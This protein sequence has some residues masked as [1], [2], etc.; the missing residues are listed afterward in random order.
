MNGSVVEILALGLDHVHVAHQQDRLGPRLA[1]RAPADDQRR[2]IVLAGGRASGVIGHDVDVSAGK[3]AALNWSATYCAIAGTLWRPITVGVLITCSNIAWVGVVLRL[4]QLAARPRARRE[5]KQRERRTVRR[6]DGA[7]RFLSPEI[8]LRHATFRAQRVKLRR[9]GPSARYSA[10]CISSRRLTVRWNSKVP[11]PGGIE[12]CG[13][14][15]GGGEQLHL[16][17]VQRVDQ[18][19]EA[20]RLVA[21]LA[22]P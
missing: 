16:M 14:G 17:L 2:G 6:A 5:R 9:R 21:H 4:R 19:D 15:V 10:L 20:R 7:L 22:G 12:S 1:G 8:E 13:L 3:P 11:S 18:R